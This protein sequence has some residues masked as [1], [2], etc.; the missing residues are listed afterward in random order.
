M[1]TL[2]DQIVVAVKWHFLIGITVTRA[3]A[4]E[5]PGASEDIKGAAA[6]ALGGV[7]VGNLSVYLPPLLSAVRSKAAAPKDQ[8]LLLRALDTVIYSLLDLPDGGPALQQAA[9]DQASS[10]LT[11]QKRCI[12]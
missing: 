8:Y 12:A 9:G 2:E 5:S 11:M 6:L 10:H 7:A 4:L 1:N 3:G